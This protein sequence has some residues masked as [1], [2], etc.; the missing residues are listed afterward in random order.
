M[1]QLLLPQAQR[2]KNEIPPDSSVAAEGS[3]SAT[4]PNDA[5]AG[6]GLMTQLALAA[7]LASPLMAA[8]ADRVAPGSFQAG[9]QGVGVDFFHPIRADR[10]DGLPFDLERRHEQADE[11]FGKAR[12]SA[13]GTHRSA[14]RWPQDVFAD[15]GKIEVGL[16]TLAVPEPGTYA[17]MLA[18][19]AAVALLV[20]RR[21]PE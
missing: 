3:P 8:A 6:A 10:F 9:V 17:L 11:I 7:L 20:R 14:D 21:R 2:S 13:K 18:G 15:S 4:G 16:P 5:S 19:L 12:H 1:I